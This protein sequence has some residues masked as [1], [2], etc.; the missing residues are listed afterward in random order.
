MSVSEGSSPN[1]PLIAARLAEFAANLDGASIPADVRRRACYLILDA[2]GCALAARRHDFASR[3][4]LAISELAGRGD[5]VVI[6]HALRLPIRDAALANGVLIHG[7]DYDD[8]HIEGLLHP[9]ASA[10]TTAFALAAH[11]GASGAELL[12]AYIVGVESAARLASVA[13]GG[14]HQIGFHPT[15]LIG[16]FSSTLIAGRL[17]GLSAAQLAHAQGIALS[18]SSGSLEFL[19]DGAWTKRIHPGWAAGSGITA[20]ALARRD[21]VGPARVYEGRFGLFPSHLGPLVQGCD[22]SCATAGLGEVWETP[23][24]AVK[25]FPSCHFTHAFADA[26]IALHRSGVDLG[27][28][29]RIRALIARESVKTVCEPLA[30]K[31]RPSNDYDSKFSVPFAIAA[32]LVHGRFGLNEH[33]DACRTDP[34]ILALAEKVQY[35]IDPGTGFPRHYSGEVIVQLDDGRELRHREQV[36][37]GCADR[38]LSNEEITDKFLENA[39]AAVSVRRAREIRDAVTA[40]DTHPSARAFAESLG[41][42]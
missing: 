37:R 26:A 23:R 33:E 31:Q 9:T 30:N 20:A 22:Y 35:E 14:F 3:S 18:M 42:H 21:F 19:E 27:R 24:V 39:S 1:P 25:P 36:N 34:R 32:G 8:T 5:G 6:G 38:P 4:L 17:Y 41:E 12:T 15:G 40:L 7:L 11:L 10:F 13:K 2:V 28:I 29:T 16:A